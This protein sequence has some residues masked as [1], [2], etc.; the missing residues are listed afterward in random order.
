MP[1]YPRIRVA[2]PPHRRGEAYGRQARPRI[3]ASVA[4]YRQAF[5]YYAGWDWDRVRVEASRFQAPIGELYPAYLA[6]MRGIAGGAGLALEDVL[7]LNVR[8][9]IMFAARARDAAAQRRR[10][11]AECTAF[12]VL[13]QASASG[14]TMVG[15]NWDWLPHCF[16][17]VVVLEVEQLGQPDYVTVVEAGLLAKAGLNS[18]GLGI[19]TNALVTDA[20]QGKPGLPYHVLLRALHDCETMTDALTVLQ[21]GGRSS[22]ANYLLAHA[23]GLVLD[24]EAAPGDFAQLSVRYPEHG[25]ALHTNHFLTPPAGIADFSLWTMP[26]SAARLGRATAELARRGPPWTAETFQRVLADHAGYPSAICCHPDHREPAQEQGATVT[27]LIIDTVE[28]RLW[29]ADGNPCTAGYRCLDYRGFLAKPPVAAAGRPAGPGVPGGRE[30]GR[31]RHQG[32]DQG[33]LPARGRG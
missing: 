26:D 3:L 25:L 24:V 28:R 31:A 7:A 19:A 29:L 5:A 21:R 12:G 20:D 23:D 6:E 27:S 11:P 32:P 17:T 10:L 22:A 4:G 2:G 18:A 9:E 8:T 15:Q 1:E 13:P 33:A 30:P 16:G 14:H